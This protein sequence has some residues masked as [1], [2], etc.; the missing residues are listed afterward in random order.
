MIDITKT[1]IGGLVDLIRKALFA[2]KNFGM[3]V[4]IDQ[5]YGRKVHAITLLYELYPYFVLHSPLSPQNSPKDFLIQRT[6]WWDCISKT[7]SN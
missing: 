2:T 3:I 5:L 7:T 1:E 4:P 6:N